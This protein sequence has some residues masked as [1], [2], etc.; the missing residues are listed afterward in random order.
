MADFKTDPFSD[1]IVPVGQTMPL[2]V[3]LLGKLIRSVSLACERTGLPFGLVG[4]WTLVFSEDRVW[5]R[6][7]LCRATGLPADALDNFME[8]LVSRSVVQV[9]ESGY[10]P[11]PAGHDERVRMAMEFLGQL[12]HALDDVLRH[13]AEVYS[14]LGGHISPAE[15]VVQLLLDGKP[16][17]RMARVAGLAA[18]LNQE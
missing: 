10:R 15:L 1:R 14:R 13:E 16:Q 3:L 11:D 6:E 2:E 7:E 9:T 4:A 12:G 5:E 18:G 8:T 17:E